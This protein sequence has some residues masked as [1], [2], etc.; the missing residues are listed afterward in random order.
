M[1]IINHHI[2]LFGASH[3]FELFHTY[4]SN[5]LEWFWPLVWSL[6]YVN[7]RYARYFYLLT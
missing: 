7:H 2:V 1:L 4:W 6:D 5:N 3:I